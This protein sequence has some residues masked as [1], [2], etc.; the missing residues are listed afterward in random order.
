MSLTHSAWLTWLLAAAMYW[1]QACTAPLAPSPSA[2]SV[3]KVAVS[4][5]A[6]PASSSS[7]T[8]PMAPRIPALCASLRS[9]CLCVGVLFVFISLY[10]L[11]G[12]G[13]RIAAKI[14]VLKRMV[15]EKT[16]EVRQ[17][18]GTQHAHERLPFHARGHAGARHNQAQ[19]HAHRHAQFPSSPA[20]GAFLT[21]S[22]RERST[23]TRR[24]LISRLSMSVEI[25]LRSME[26]R[27]W[28]RASRCSRCISSAAWSRRSRYRITRPRKPTNRTTTIT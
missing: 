6:Q 21:A 27:I 2:F 10:L 3:R 17:Q 23:L 13:R 15:L 18:R 26:P 22:A 12:Y 8:S 11:F 14:D 7:P 24:A 20:H 5:L 9:L 4:K 19:H 1:F 16:P 25:V 28:L